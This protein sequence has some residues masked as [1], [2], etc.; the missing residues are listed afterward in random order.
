MRVKRDA[1]QRRRDAI[2]RQVSEANDAAH[3]AAAEGNRVG[4]AT[5]LKRR[6]MH[7]KDAAQVTKLI[8]AADRQLGAI[9]QASLSASMAETVRDGAAVMSSVHSQLNPAAVE[10]DMSRMQVQ[11]READYVTRMMTRPIGSLSPDDDVDMDNEEDAAIAD[12]L[13]SI[14]QSASLAADA[15]RT[16]TTTP[17]E[18]LDQS[19]AATTNPSVDLK[20]LEASLGL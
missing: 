17:V 1:M 3:R 20:N 2:E 14:M 11:A 15:P 13:A 10:R 4:A 7:E 5:A 8:V 12:E 19:V 9:E 18:S 6:A 16:P